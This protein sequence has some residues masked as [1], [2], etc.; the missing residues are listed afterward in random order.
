[1]DSLYYS[2]G[3]AIVWVHECGNNADIWKQLVQKL[4]PFCLQCSRYERH[5]SDIFARPIKTINYST[6]DRIIAGLKYDGNFV[7][8]RL[9]GQGRAA[10]ARRDHHGHLTLN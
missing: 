10:A 8:R 4:E 1:M 3:V 9:R 7:G 2:F 6:L 5:T